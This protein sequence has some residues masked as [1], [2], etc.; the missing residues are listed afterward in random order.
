MKAIALNIAN[1]ITMRNFFQCFIVFFSLSCVALA[2]EIPQLN[3]WITDQTG[4]LSSGQLAEL[5]DR[6]KRYEDSTSTRFAILIVSSLDGYAI[7]DYSMEVVKKNQMSKGDK[8]NALL[9]LVSIGDRKMR[10]ETGYGVEARLTDALSSAI[11]SS[12]VK[13]HFKRK[14]YYEGIVAG[15]NAAMQ[16]ME[17]EYEANK[18]SSDS[19]VGPVIFF[20]AVILLIIFASILRQRLRGGLQRT[21]GGTWF[22]G[23]GGW[24]SGSYHSGSSWG[25]SSSSD[26]G[27][28][29]G[30]GGWSSGGDSFGGGGASGDW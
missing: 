27:S 4:T 11:I 29:W 24:G 1:R 21:T 20:V 14:D 18:K 15:M 9:F 12:E 13:P 3:A 10:F 26:S 5:N 23:T 25:G 28:S 19:E 8:H 17:G 30:G 7:E 6:L 16:A 22:V 2:A